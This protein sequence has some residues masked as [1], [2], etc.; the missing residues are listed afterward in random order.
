MISKKFTRYSIA[1]IGMLILSALSLPAL[2]QNIRVDVEEANNGCYQA[3][4]YN[5]SN[6]EMRVTL[7]Y[8]YK[9]SN[10]LD[11]NR[12]YYQ[13]RIVGVVAYANQ[14]ST[15]L[16]FSG[17]VDCDKPYTVRITNWNWEAQ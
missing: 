14:K 12:A 15:K 2:T 6:Q 11:D 9:G 10:R 1:M 7:D 13:D 17:P 16:L 4:I 8:E 3:A 5:N